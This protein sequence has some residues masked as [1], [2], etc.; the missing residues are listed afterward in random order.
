ME[1]RGK[2]HYEWEKI[3]PIITNPDENH[4][5]EPDAVNKQLDDLFVEYLGIEGIGNM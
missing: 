4:Q 3:A 1:T 5:E 2:A